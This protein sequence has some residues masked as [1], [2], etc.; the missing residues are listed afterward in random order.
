[1]GKHPFSVCA[2]QW[3]LQQLHLCRLRVPCCACEDASPL[4]PQR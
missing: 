4:L 3:L 1:V 2:Q